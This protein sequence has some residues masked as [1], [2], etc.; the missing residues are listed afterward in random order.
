MSISVCRMSFIPLKLGGTGLQFRDNQVVRRRRLQ[1][2]LSNKKSLGTIVI[3]Q[4]SRV[5]KR[6]PR[7]T[8]VVIHSKQLKH[9]CP[10]YYY[11]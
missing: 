9:C 4:A 10:P 8:Q 5:P 3:I 11:L 2:H 6:V 1:M 7:K